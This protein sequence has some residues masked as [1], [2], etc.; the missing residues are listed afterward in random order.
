MK[1]SEINDVIDDTMRMGMTFE[2][3]IK[4]IKVVLVD[5][6]RRLAEV[7]RRLDGS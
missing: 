6:E 7:E 2:G 1:P 4:A 5:L 3:T